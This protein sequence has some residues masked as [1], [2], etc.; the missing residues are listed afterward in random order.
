[1][2]RWMKKEKKEAV[3]IQYEDE[4]KLFGAM[5]L[6]ST[7]PNE[8][9]PVFEKDKQLFLQKYEV[10]TIIDDFVLIGEEYYPLIQALDPEKCIKGELKNHYSIGS[11]CVVGLQLSEDSY[12]LGNYES[13][14]QSLANGKISINNPCIQEDIDHLGKMNKLKK[15]YLKSKRFHN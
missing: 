10:S 9:Y 5:F 11:D 8:I 1:M 13:L 15:E 6:F 14:V 4:Y 3:G 12:F 2:V 7:Y